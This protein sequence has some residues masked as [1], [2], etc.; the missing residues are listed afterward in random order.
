MVPKLT[1]DS[2]ASH[3]FGQPSSARAALHCAGVISAYLSFLRA[4][5]EFHP[6][7]S[8]EHDASQFQSYPN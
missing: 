8:I 4:L 1:L 3:S 6:A 7:I 2:L 5:P